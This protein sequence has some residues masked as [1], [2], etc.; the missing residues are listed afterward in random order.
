M[1]TAAPTSSQGPDL[2]LWFGRYRRRS[3][4]ARAASEPLAHQRLVLLVE[5]RGGVAVAHRRAVHPRERRRV[6]EQRLGS[7]CTQSIP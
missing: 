4:V 3:S 1:R 6:L 2:F 7:A 5:V